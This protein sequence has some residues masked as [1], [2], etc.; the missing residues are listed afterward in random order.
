VMDLFHT[1]FHEGICFDSWGR[2]MQ[3]LIMDLY[4]F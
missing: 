1:I 2:S 4:L 3:G